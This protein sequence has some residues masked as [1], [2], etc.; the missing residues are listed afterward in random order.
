MDS[1]GLHIF[2]YQIIVFIIFILFII[3]IILSLTNPNKSFSD[4]ISVNIYN[5]I[6]VPN[7]YK[8]YIINHIPYINYSPCD[9]TQQII[10]IVPD[11]IVN[12]ISTNIDIREKFIQEQE[13]EQEQ[14]IQ[15][16]NKNKMNSNNNQH[17]QPNQPWDNLLNECKNMQGTIDDIDWK[18][19]VYGYRPKI[20]LY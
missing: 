16:N 17:N 9:I 13:Q 20:I 14:E 6:P 8:D 15:I 4:F 19:Y 11:N 10:D 2:F 7:K 5:S 12:Y 3:L 18:A 1:D